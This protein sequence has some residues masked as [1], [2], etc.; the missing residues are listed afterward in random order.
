MASAS[1]SPAEAAAVLEEV[2]AVS[3]IDLET[4]FFPWSADHYLATGVTV[5]P[6]AFD[7]L[8][9]NYDAIFMGAFGDPRVPDMRHAAEILLGARFRLDLYV[10]YRPVRCLDDR[11]SRSRPSPPGTSTSSSSARTPRAPTSASAATSRRAR[12]TR[13]R[14]RRTSPRARA[15]SGSSGYAF[16]HA[17]TRGAKAA[18]SCPTSPTRCASSGDLWQRAFAEVARGYPDIRVVAPLRRRAVHAARSGIPAQFDVIVTNNMFGDI[19]DG[20]GRGAAGGP[21]DGRIRQHP[22]RPG[23]D[24]RA[25][26]RL[27]AQVRRDGQG[28]PLRRDPDRRRSCS[29]HL[30]H[31]EEAA[32]IERAVAECVRRRGVHG[33]RRRGR[34][35]P[36]QAGDAVCRRL[37]PAWTGGARAASW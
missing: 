12:P 22:S 2:A 9:S 7:D 11:L 30:G 37:A 8:A 24:V 14:S 5:P 32:A 19:V 13:S 20:S 35:R 34:S 10:N 31:P 6:G 26:A 15:S 16:E 23:L 1:R 28:E 17:R 18:S 4:V 36:A 3:S 21:R 29:T 33:R 25:G 27:G